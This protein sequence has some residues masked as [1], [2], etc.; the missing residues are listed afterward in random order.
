M[1]FSDSIAQSGG[2]VRYSPNGNFV[3]IAK[4]FDLKIFETNSLWPLVTLLFADLVSEV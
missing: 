1:N 4:S 2:L 3:A